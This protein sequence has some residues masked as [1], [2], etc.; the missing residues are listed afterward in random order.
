MNNT[1]EYLDELYESQPTRG[2]MG[3]SRDTEVNTRMAH[4]KRCEDKLNRYRNQESPVLRLFVER[5]LTL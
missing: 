5:L 4:L 3:S 1:Y 2:K